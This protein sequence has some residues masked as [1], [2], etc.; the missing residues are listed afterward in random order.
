M[1]I[2]RVMQLS[3]LVAAGFMMTATL[4][5]P[6]QAARPVNSR[7]DNTSYTAKRLQ[8]IVE[9]PF[10]VKS[11]CEYN[12]MNYWQPYNGHCLLDSE[13]AGS[14]RWWIWAD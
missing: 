8:H 4:A 13:W 5:A 1:L 2:R 12:A 10:Y 7:T 6:A 9:G 14:S 11:Q 3:S